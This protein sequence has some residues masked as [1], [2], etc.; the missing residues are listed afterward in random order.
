MNIKKNFYNCKKT[1]L[2]ILTVITINLIAALFIGR[3]IFLM[4]DISL[5]AP[6]KLRSK[7]QNWLIS[8]SDGNAYNGKENNVHEA[9]QNFLTYVTINKGFD[10]VINY[11]SQHI[12]P[13][14]YEENKRILDQNRGAGYWLWKPYIILKTLDKMEE[15]DFLFY[16]DAGVMFL[17]HAEDFIE[18]LNENNKDIILFGNWHTNRTYVKKDLYS[19]MNISE[20]YRDL[21]QLDAGVCIVIRNTEKSRNFMRNWL[22]HCKDERLLTDIKSKGEEFSDFNEHRHDQAIL[23]MLYYK[24]PEN[25]LLIKQQDYTYLWKGLCR[26][27]RRDPQ[28]SLLWIK[29]RKRFPSWI[30]NTIDVFM[31]TIDIFMIPLTQIE[32]FL[33]NIKKI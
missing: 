8:Y 26:H 1:I 28:S 32:G 17:G 22:N 15:G 14:F 5:I 27:H 3:S 21:L 20:K 4:N 25:I 12:D 19:I 31:T 11:K 13:K 29:W 10:A 7:T 6:I 18:K 2:F 23:T 16:V 24:N 30:N 33:H 9:N